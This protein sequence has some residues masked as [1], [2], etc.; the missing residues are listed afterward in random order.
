MIDGV[1]VNRYPACLEASYFQLIV[2]KKAL[3]SYIVYYCSIMQS[4]SS[5]NIFKSFIIETI[6]GYSPVGGAF[7]QRDRDAVGKIN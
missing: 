6:L 7:V 2:L 1:G 3:G 4:V 5:N